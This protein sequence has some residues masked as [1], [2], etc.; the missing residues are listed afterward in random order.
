[1]R[2]KAGESGDVF[3]PSLIQAGGEEET[4]YQ[5]IQRNLCQS[6]HV[7]I[8]HLLGSVGREAEGGGDRR[9]GGEGERKEKER[10]MI[11]REESRG[12]WND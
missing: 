1:M 4:H 7:G 11:K 2:R 12:G 5:L 6:W 9:K 8:H 10:R 3:L